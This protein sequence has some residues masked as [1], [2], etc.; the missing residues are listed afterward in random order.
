MSAFRLN[1]YTP[2]G[3]VI[4]EL[5]CND[6]LIPTVGGQVN[7]LKD[8]TH[9]LAEL[10]TGPLIVKTDNGVKHFS[11]TAGTCKVLDQEITILSLTSETAEKIDLD[12]AKKAKEIAADKLS[13]KETLTDLE[14]T[15]Y[16]RKLERAEMRIKIGY[17]RGN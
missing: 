1:L 7:V 8:H 16:Q 6:V 14:L 3:I 11:V 10:G 12:R 13:G 9:F 15:K 4:K 2:S 5:G 17:L